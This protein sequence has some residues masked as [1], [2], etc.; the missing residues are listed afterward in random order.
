MPADPIYWTQSVLLSL[1]EL[2]HP[3]F[4][5]SLSRLITSAATHL[6]LFPFAVLLLLVDKS[7]QI[8]FE[9]LDHTSV[10]RSDNVGAGASA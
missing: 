6:C 5:G 1:V 2:L 3:R 9:S 8:M 10:D 4:D 7:S